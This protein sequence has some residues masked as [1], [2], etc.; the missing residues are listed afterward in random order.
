MTRADFLA[1]L[2]AAGM[3]QTRFAS[4]VGIPADRV[5]NWGNQTHPIPPWVGRVLD[6]WEREAALRAQLDALRRGAVEASPEDVLDG[7][8]IIPLQPGPHADAVRKLSAALVKEP[9]DV[10]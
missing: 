5:W 6:G 3:T 4:E 9:A 8:T 7:L 2:K 1:R 10:A